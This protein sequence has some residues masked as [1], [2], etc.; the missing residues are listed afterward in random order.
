VPDDPLDPEEQISSFRAF[1]EAGSV[2]FNEGNLDLAIGGFPEDLEWHPVSENPEQDVHRGPAEIKAWF[3][4]FRSVFDEWRVEPLDFE[5]VADYAVLV[6]HIIRGTS[7]SA[8]VP[9]EVETWELW[10]LGPADEATPE[11]W[12]L[13]GLRPLRVRQFFSRDEALA[14]AGD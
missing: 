14:A 7:R 4:N 11:A 9:V 12:R 3:E 6:H 13:I 5:L 2:A 10:E 8:G 1:Y